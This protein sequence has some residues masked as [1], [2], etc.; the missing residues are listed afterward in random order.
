MSKSLPRNY[1]YYLRN[2]DTVLYQSLRG[3]I[4]DETD[5]VSIILI[6]SEMLLFLTDLTKYYI[7]KNQY[8]VEYEVKIT[9]ETNV[10]YRYKLFFTN[11]FSEFSRQTIR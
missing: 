10:I 7:N 6:L 11:I 2:F 9:T 5:N 4:L 3:L 1:L 8:E